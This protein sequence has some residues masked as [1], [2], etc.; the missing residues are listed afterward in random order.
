MTRII[1]TKF[2]NVI[3]WSHSLEVPPQHIE[4]LSKTWKEH[5]FPHKSIIFLYWIAWN[6]LNHSSPYN[7]Y[8]LKWQKKEMLWIGFKD[9]NEGLFSL[10]LCVSSEFVKCPSGWDKRAIAADPQRVRPDPLCL[11]LSSQ[12]GQDGGRQNQL[13]FTWPASD[14]PDTCTSG[15]I[16]RH[17]TWHL[18]SRLQFYRLSAHGLITCLF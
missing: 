4:L 13:P 17:I 16:T 11:W 15:Y 3:L 10:F 7:M 18:N 5:N 14:S 12:R 9:W 2:G 1:Q 8:K 6:R